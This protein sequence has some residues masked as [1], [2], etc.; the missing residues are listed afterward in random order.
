MLKQ[1]Q[2]LMKLPG[3]A[4]PTMEKKIKINDTDDAASNF[5]HLRSIE[6]KISQFFN[7]K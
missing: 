2:I 4:V 1:C 7:N 3:D 6:F 5:S